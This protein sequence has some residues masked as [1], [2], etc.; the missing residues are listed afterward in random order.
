[1]KAA[2]GQ[3]TPADRHVGRRARSALLLVAGL[4]AASV[5]VPVSGA[6]ASSEMTG[7]TRSESFSEALLATPRTFRTALVAVSRPGND[8]ALIVRL[9]KWTKLLRELLPAYWTAATDGL[10]ALEIPPVE[11]LADQAGTGAE[12]ELA[13]AFYRTHADEYDF[14]LFVALWRS[15]DPVGRHTTYKQTQAGTG[16][17]IASYRRVPGADRLLGVNM[18]F[19]EA[20]S[21]DADDPLVATALHEIHHQWCCS[22]LAPDGYG[23]DRYALLDGDPGSHWSR[24]LFVPPRPRI[25]I[26]GGGS[27]RGGGWAENGDGTFTPDCTYAAFT[28]NSYH[29]GKLGLYLMGLIPA[30]QVPPVQL[31]IP[32]SGPTGKT[33]HC[34]DPTTIRARK[35]SIPIDAIIRTNGIVA[36]VERPDISSVRAGLHSR[37]LAQAASPRLTRGEKKWL[38]VAFQ[39][40]GSRAWIR[41]TF[42]EVR[43][44]VSGDDT[45]IARSGIAVNWLSPTRLAVQSESAVYAGY[46]A[47]FAFQVEGVRSGTYRLNVNPVVDGV[48]WLEDDGVHFEIVV[49]EAPLQGVPTK[50]VYLPNVTKRLGGEAG[51]QTPFI[52]QNVGSSTTDLEITFFAFGDGALVTRRIVRG[53]MPGRSFAE[54]PNADPDLPPEGQFSVVVRSFGSDIVSVVNAQRADGSPRAEAMSYA[55]SSAGATSV[56]LPYVAKAVGGW[57]TTMVVQNLGSSVTTVTATFVGKDGASAATLTRQLTGGRS[58]FIDPSAE[59]ALQRGS[60][61]SVTLSASQPIAAVVNAHNDA[62]SEP[63]PRAASYNGVPGPEVG[64]TTYLPHFFASFSTNP[65]RIV[66]QNA[67]QTSARPLLTFRSLAGAGSKTALAPASIAP[68]AAWAFDV[69]QSLDGSGTCLTVGRPEC[70]GDGEYSVVVSGGR[71]AVAALQLDRS[72]AVAFTGRASGAPRLHLPNATRSLGG[73]DGW[74]TPILLQ[75]A[76]ATVATLRWYRFSDGALVHTQTID[77]IAP[78]AT[79]RLDPRILSA[80]TDDGQYSVTIDANGGIVAIVM[81]RNAFAGDG[82]M[83]Y[84]AFP[85]QP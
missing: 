32:E 82:A 19:P 63:S 44:G 68:G 4:V 57:T 35:I 61:Y 3:R 7:A 42:T 73:V 85:T 37:W 51:W 83:T 11:T 75:S 34:S 70:L 10:S 52:V 40:T 76:G 54:L 55:G 69:T 25:P 53:L 15:G 20:S 59:P 23:V 22:L 12:R 47:T 43:L 58:Q 72:T 79:V 16:E 36:R 13:E 41:G 18:L 6:A 49:E 28:P 50:V 26:I 56:Y 24:F 39:N 1:M 66:V 81:Q 64:S 74:T 65:G 29:F 5:A 21:L 14:L 38:W 17:T 84:E 8:P 62:A 48:Q 33:G 67:G 77:G 30:E 2:E 31:L 27:Y 80:L 9:T 60:E 71:F 45:S 46:V 78:G